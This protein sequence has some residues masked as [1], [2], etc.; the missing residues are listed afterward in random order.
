[1]ARFGV[2]EVCD[3]T[4]YNTLNEPV[5]FLDTLKLSN[6]ENDAERSYATGGKGNA[7]LLSFDYNRTAN[8]TI[9][10]A[11][12]N[13]KTISMQLGTEIRTEIALIY[14]REVLTVTGTA[15]RTVL[16]EEMPEG[17]VTI[18]S[19]LNGYDH[20]TKEVITDPASQTITVPAGIT[21][22]QVIVYY[23]YNTA[24]AVDTMVISSDKFSGF[25]KIVGKT[26]IKNFETKEDEAFQILIP[27]AKI[28]SAFEISMTSE[29]DPSVFD[30]TLEV[31]KPD[32]GTDMVLMTRY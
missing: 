4:F 3:V 22:N 15:P 19:T 16:L 29:G 8:F 12:L 7:R 20:G 18:Y 26:T 24:S 13:P 17:D 14:H 9:Q 11:L 10:D 5:L 2:R 25:Y 1:M 21:T 27:Q 23:S 31:Y 28:A 32:K 30:M 6:L